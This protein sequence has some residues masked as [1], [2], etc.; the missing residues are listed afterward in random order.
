MVW[1][2]SVPHHTAPERA[3][4]L[5][6]PH[7]GKFSSAGFCLPLNLNLF[8]FLA[9]W[10]SGQA[11]LTLMLPSFLCFILDLPPHPCAWSDL[12]GHG[13]Y[14]G[15]DCSAIGVLLREIKVIW[16]CYLQTHWPWE[17]VFILQLTACLSSWVFDS[18][19]RVVLFPITFLWA[20]YLDSR[21]PFLPRGAPK[22]TQSTGHT[23][24]N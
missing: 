15:S 12:M 4:G 20:A 19:P 14:G 8:L 18:C 1:K 7:L 22:H 11:H 10:V 17:P 13:L 23:L 3:A 16:P 2:V 6:Q 9:E 5:Y 21:A 24:L